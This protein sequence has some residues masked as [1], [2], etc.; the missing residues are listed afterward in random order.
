MTRFLSEGVQRH[1][2]P[3]NTLNALVEEARKKRIKGKGKFCYV[4]VSMLTLGSRLD[5][6]VTFFDAVVHQMNIKANK[7]DVAVNLR[8][9]W[10]ARE[11]PLD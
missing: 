3:A 9:E 2:L 1:K 11:N 5:F 10:D 4:P 7:G 8:S 6:V